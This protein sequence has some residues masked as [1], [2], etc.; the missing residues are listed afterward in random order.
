VGAGDVL[1]QIVPSNSRLQIDVLIPNEEMG[2]IRTNRPVD[3]KF[4]AFPFQKYGRMAGTL[5]WV[6]PDAELVTTSNLPMLSSAATL[7]V[8][9]GGTH[10]FYRGIVQL[11]PASNPQIQSAPGMTVQADIHTDR[12]RIIDFLLFPIRQSVEEGLRVR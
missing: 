10:Y 11:Q 7:R 3:I 8:T 2:Y 9:R 4:D 5:T 6:S 1:V 12:R